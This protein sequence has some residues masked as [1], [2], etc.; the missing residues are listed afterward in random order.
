MHAPSD[1]PRQVADYITAYWDDGM[2][3]GQIEC[4]ESEKELNRLVAARAG[5]PLPIDPID[6]KE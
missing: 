3:Q 6:P 4:Q 1:G 2:G 5:V